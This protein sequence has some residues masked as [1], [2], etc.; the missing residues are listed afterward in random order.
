MELLNDW[1]LSLNFGF[2][3]QKWRFRISPS[4][5]V[6]QPSQLHIFFFIVT[7]ALTYT[8]IPSTFH[9]LQYQYIERNSVLWEPLAVE[10]SVTVGIS[11]LMYSQQNV[12]YKFSHVGCRRLWASVSPLLQ[13]LCHFPAQCVMQVDYLCL[14]R[15][16]PGT[17]WWHTVFT[18]CLS[19]KGKLRWNNST[20]RQTNCWFGLSRPIAISFYLELM[21][22]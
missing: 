19:E 2:I 11:T 9:E 16:C 17:Q 21:Q 20:F 14:D 10:A 15:A 6:R 7:S 18:V 5:Y 13:T 8:N 4:V 12:T 3:L 22:N 1:L